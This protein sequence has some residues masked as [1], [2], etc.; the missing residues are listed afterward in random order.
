[1]MQQSFGQA[2]GSISSLNTEGWMNETMILLL[3]LFQTG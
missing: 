3:I 1:M 2:K